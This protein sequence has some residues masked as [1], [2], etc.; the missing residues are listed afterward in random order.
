MGRVF[1]LQHFS[2][3]ETVEYFLR[4]PSN[5]MCCIF[6]PA[7]TGPS[8]PITVLCFEIRINYVLFIPAAVSCGTPAAPVNGGVLALDYSA[9]TRATYFCNEG[10][11]LSSKEVTSTVCQADGTWSNHNKIPRCTGET[12]RSH[13]RVSTRPRL[14]QPT[15]GSRFKQ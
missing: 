15:R 9:A 13:T 3:F 14:H 11:R 6:I 4:C 1:I 5:A 2:L 12:Q 7:L 10:F 8:C